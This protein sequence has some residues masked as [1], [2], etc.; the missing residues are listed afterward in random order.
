MDGDKFPICPHCAEEIK[1]I[2]WFNEEVANLRIFICPH[3]RK[4]LSIQE[5]YGIGTGLP[6]APAIPRQTEPF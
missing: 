5:W 4:I 1:G 3:C 2:E 6:A